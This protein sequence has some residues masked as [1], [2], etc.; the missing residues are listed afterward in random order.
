M[1]QFNRIKPHQR[2]RSRADRGFWL[3]TTNYY[4]FAIAVCIASFFL[5][6]AILDDL[7]ERS[8]WIGAG[9]ISSSVLAFAVL[10][11][12]FVIRL[13][14]RRQV[15]EQAR[16]DKTLLAVAS[17]RNEKKE[18]KLTAEQNK[19]WIAF[20]VTRSNAARVLGRV[21]EAHREVFE[22]CDEYLRSVRTEITLV[23][24]GS[25]RIGAFKR[26]I[27]RIASIHRFHML[28]WAEIESRQAV[29]DAKNRV[30]IGERF[31]LMAN[32]ESALSFALSFYPEDP[33]L[34]TSH[35]A[36][37]RLI[38]QFDGDLAAEEENAFD[39][40]EPIGIEIQTTIF[41]DEGEELKQAEFIFEDIDDAEQPENEDPLDAR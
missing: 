1:N 30:N 11:R 22:I 12:E 6:W 17:Q 36:L 14:R 37:S 19:E 26:G 32:A 28:K 15:A 40:A 16:L 13:H 8:P 20:I 23:S 31:R 2:A 21:G 5:A 35:A 34:V 3:R 29:L 9:L 24:P 7:G 33:D 39:Q 4:F 18:S 25:P 38:D 41:T 27:D 10:L